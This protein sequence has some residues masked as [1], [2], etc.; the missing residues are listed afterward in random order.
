[1]S[2]KKIFFNILMFRIINIFFIVFLFVFI[3]LPL[4]FIYAVAISDQYDVLT[5]QKASTASNHTIVFLT[6][7]GAGQSTDT[8]VV[9]LP[10]GFT[11]NSFDF[12]DVDL[13]HSAGS[14]TDC[15]APTFSNDETLAATP[16]ATAWGASLSSQVLTLTAPTDGVGVAAIATNACVRIKIGT[17][18]TTGGTGDTQIT[19]HATPGSYVISISGTFGGL[20]DITINVLSDDQVLL[21]GTV[22]EVLTFSIS[23]IDIGFGSLLSGSARYAT[24]DTLGSGSDTADAH[25][26][27]AS[28]NASNGYSI[29]I[30][31]FNLRSVIPNTI[32]AIGAT[33]V[34][35]SPGTEQFG[36]RLIVNSGT[37]SVASPY[38]SANWALDINSFPDQI[39]S[40]AGDG[41][42]TT[43]GVRYIGNISVLTE[44]GDY[45]TNLTYIITANF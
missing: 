45:H 18:A 10:S 2:K 44:A 33:A 23:D 22:N 41:T 25:T 15:V 19:N 5:S 26:I 39:A 31:G 42:T 6:P 29:T 24:G 8:I 40:G 12:A 4:Q 16:S 37:G 30:D 34:A 21:T 28:S 36:M 7:I 17:N 27:S 1:M 9:T 38:N 20:G 13:A 32:T 11:T 43:F 35:S 3:L 14:Q